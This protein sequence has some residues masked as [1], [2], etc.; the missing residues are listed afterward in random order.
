[1]GA[2]AVGTLIGAL[3]KT[4]KAFIV[5]RALAGIGAGG[6]FNG[7]MVIIT[8]AAP[9]EVRPQMLSMS[10]VMVGIGGVIGP[11]I[12]G[13]VTQH[14]GWR[15]CRSA[16][17]FCSTLELT[18]PRGLWIFLP[19]SGLV[20][21]IFFMQCI[22]EQVGLEKPSVWNAV[23]HLH[24]KLDL[25]GFSLFTPATIMFLLSVSWAGSKYAWDSAT[26]IGLLVGSAVTLCLFCLWV[27]HYQDRALLPP[28]ILMKPAI[29]HGCIISF[30][31]GGSFIM[32]QQ[33]LPLWFQSV[34]GANPQNG[35]L[36]MLPTCIAQI[37]TGMGC[38]ALRKFSLH[39]PFTVPTHSF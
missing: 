6:L 31:Q 12:G 13:A 33:Y 37:I 21:F 34:K 11:V 32:L 8:A 15:W 10:V 16:I 25:I 26:T 20:A 5:G 17:Q 9:P 27:R 36:M 19:P 38:S 39:V 35:G 1:M 7:G 4:S 29:L 24:H 22:P 30:M 18:F 28:S 2:F 3:S 23:R 14:L